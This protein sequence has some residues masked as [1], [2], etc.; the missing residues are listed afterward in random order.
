MYNL[1]LDTVSLLVKW[2]C[3]CLDSNCFLFISA[4]LSFSSCCFFTHVSYDSL[5]IRFCSFL[6]HII[7][8]A[9]NLICQQ[10]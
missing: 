7:A 2:V 9:M 5:S 6:Q 1:P 8:I 3:F 10:Y 4:C